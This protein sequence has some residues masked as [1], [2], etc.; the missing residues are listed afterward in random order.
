MFENAFLFIRWMERKE[1]CNHL[2]ALW[3]III[4]TVMAAK[5]IKKADMIRKI[6]KVAVISLIIRKLIDPL[7]ELRTRINPKV[8]VAVKKKINGKII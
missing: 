2:V 3:V 4:E 5:A 7:R 8:E 6:N 1:F